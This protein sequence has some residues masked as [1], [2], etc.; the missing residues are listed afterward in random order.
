MEDFVELSKVL[1]PGVYALMYGPRLK[2]IGKAKRLLHRIYSHKIL[3]DRLRKGGRAPLNGPAGVKVIQFDRVMIRPCSL[4]E[5]ERLERELIAKYSPP[6][7]THHKPKPPTKTL[8]EL[9]FDFASIGLTPN[10]MPI[11][12]PLIGFVRRF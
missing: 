1:G 3:Y 12:E 7:N 11:P 8:A 5:L 9:G 6:N 4:G 2:Y 10:F